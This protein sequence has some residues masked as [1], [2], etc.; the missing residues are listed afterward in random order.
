MRTGKSW[1]FWLGLFILVTAAFYVVTGT[2]YVIKGDFIIDV[3]TS[4]A[5]T[6]FVFFLVGLYMTYSGRNKP[7]SP[8]ETILF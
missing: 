6:G 3:N 5:V 2:Y 8:D 4:N 7:G 1:V